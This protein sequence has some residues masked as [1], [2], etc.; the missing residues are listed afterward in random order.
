MEKECDIYNFVIF[1]NLPIATRVAKAVLS[2]GHRVIG[3]VIEEASSNYWDPFD[4]SGL[5]EFCE[6]KGIPWGSW[7]SISEAFTEHKPQIGVAARFSKRIPLDVISSF[8]HGILNFHGGLLPSYAGPYSPIH[9]IL[10]GEHEGGSTIHWIDEG[11]DTGPVVSRKKFPIEASDT[12]LE[13]FQKTQLSLIEQFATLMSDLERTLN[14]PEITFDD[15]E[16][17]YY[18]KSDILGQKDVSSLFSKIPE[19]EVLRKVRAFD[20]PGHEPAFLIADGHKIF[21]RTRPM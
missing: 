10:N 18:S 2:Q 1:G 15:E 19:A 21:L 11:F 3:A 17:R 8:S 14:L 16:W 13:V 5:K 6:D 20:H 7:N 4:D 12:V 9:M